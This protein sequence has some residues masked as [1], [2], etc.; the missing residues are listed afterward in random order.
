MKLK[1][2]TI[3][4]S[5]V[6]SLPFNYSRELTGY[7]VK[8]KIYYRKGNKI[9][10]PIFPDKKITF[11]THLDVMPT[12]EAVTY[13]D[14]PSPV[15]MLVFLV[16]D[17]KKMYIKSTRVII[18]FEKTKYTKSIAVKAVECVLKNNKYWKEMARKNL[19]DRMFFYVLHYINRKI[20]P[21]NKFWN[22]SWK[23]LVEQILK[24][25]VTIL[26]SDIKDPL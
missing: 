19:N 6:N 11:H 4:S 10:C 17:S 23:R 5:A 18:V 9:N 24:I 12:R 3:R 13:P 7:I 15:D 1:T 2:K 16:A 26:T 20:P 21:R 14:I 25:N 22:F 8:N